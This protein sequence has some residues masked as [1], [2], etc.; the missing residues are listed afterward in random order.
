MRTVGTSIDGIDI[1]HLH[2][3]QDDSES[4]LNM[5]L[6]HSGEVESP[7]TLKCASILQYLAGWLI[8]G[9]YKARSCM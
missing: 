8:L 9:G 3:S 5:K 2:F 6:L 1:V 4:P 7:Q